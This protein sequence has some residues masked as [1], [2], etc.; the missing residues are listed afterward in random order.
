MDSPFIG[1]RDLALHTSGD[2]VGHTNNDGRPFGVVMDMG[3]PK[4]TATVVA[5][6]DGSASIY[7]SSGGGYIG[8][9]GQDA[10]KKVAKAAVA[11]A[12]GV[13]SSLHPTH[14]YPLP[15]PGFVS[16]YVLTGRGVFTASVAEQFDDRNMPLRTIY[17]AMQDVITQYRLLNP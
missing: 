6:E 10:V 11:T 15:A 9:G 12:A 4:G 2:T 5:F 8:G 3:F 7:T 1:L 14:E 13:L 17:A 16:F